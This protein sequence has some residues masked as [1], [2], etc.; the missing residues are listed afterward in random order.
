[1]DKISTEAAQIQR[2]FA[3]A[4]VAFGGWVGLVI[5]MKLLS[6]AL[7]RERTDYEPDAGACLACARCFESCPN[8][9]A[10][11]GLVAPIST[12]APATPQAV[13]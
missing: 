11:R 8:E 6:L 13:S 1:V 4:S 9:I 10:R 5:G 7:R 2:K 12:P 3:L